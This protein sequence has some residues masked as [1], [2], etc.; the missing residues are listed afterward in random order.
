MSDQPVLS[1]FTTQPV[2][3]SCGDGTSRPFS[4]VG[5]VSAHSSG[6]RQHYSHYTPALE[7]GINDQ[8]AAVSALAGSH[9]RGAAIIR[10]QQ[11]DARNAR[12]QRKHEQQVQ[13]DT[14]LREL[15]DDTA[16]RMADRTAR[17][18]RDLQRQHA[19][20]GSRQSSRPRGE[21][22]RVM[23]CQPRAMP[24]SSTVRSATP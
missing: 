4:R 3:G 19:G 23:K 6:V 21:R 22:A 24:T 14:T 20:Q 11:R 5:G 10:R 8:K 17:L 1:L 15:K 7:W 12:R 18:Q 13:L 9:G 2:R 16:Q